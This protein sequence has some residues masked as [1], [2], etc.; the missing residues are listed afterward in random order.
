MSFRGAPTREP[1]ISILGPSSN[2]QIPDRRWRGVRNDW[3]SFFEQPV[4]GFFENHRELFSPST[5]EGFR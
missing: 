4:T 2:I 3:E 5:L 1:G